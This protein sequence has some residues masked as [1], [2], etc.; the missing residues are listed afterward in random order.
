MKWNNVTQIAES[1]HKYHCEDDV[2]RI[3]LCDLHD[4]IVHLDDFEDN[5][6]SSNKKLLQSILDCWQELIEQ[7]QSIN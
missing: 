2:S 1:L 3:A 7:E 6:E 4:I 5:A